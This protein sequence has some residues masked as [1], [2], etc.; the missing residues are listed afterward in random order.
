MGP[1][2]FHSPPFMKGRK[3]TRL[4]QEHMDKVRSIGCI[5]CK[6]YG[7][8]RYAEIHHVIGKTKPNAHYKVLPLCP[9]HHRNFL[10]KDG[11]PISVHPYKAR[12]EAKYGKQET[13][14]EEVQ[15]IIDN[16]NYYNIF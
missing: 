9:D 10:Y 6:K 15:K 13:L 4:E 5:I 7:K 11:G 3:P 2:S 14:L 8:S 12:F 1:V 16:M